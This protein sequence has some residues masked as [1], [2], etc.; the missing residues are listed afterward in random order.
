MEDIQS[1]NL[2]YHNPDSTWTAFDINNYQE[3]LSKVLVKGVF[4][5]KVP[6]DVINS[7][8]IYEHHVAHAW[9]SYPAMDDAVTKLVFTTEIAIKQ[10]CMQMGIDIR[11]FTPKGHKNINLSDL[12]D[13][14]TKVEPDK[15]LSGMLHQIRELRN[16]I[17]HPD[18]YSFGFG[19][20][21]LTKPIV[22]AINLLYLD[23]SVVKEQLEEQRRLQSEID[24]LSDGCF[25]ITDDKIYHLALRIKVLGSVKIKDDWYYSISAF[26]IDP[27]Y[28][29]HIP[30]GA[31]P[32]PIG[33]MA[34]NIKIENNEMNFWDLINDEQIK[35]HLSQKPEYISLKQDYLKTFEEHFA[36]DDFNK[37]RFEA[38]ESMENGKLKFDFLYQKL[39]LI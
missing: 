10:R 20:M 33:F 17:A 1:N 26:I 28:K 25:Y 11:K 24:N 23:N 15:D 34:R 5:K 38:L 6:V 16:S 29:I 35:I 7:Y 19:M 12:I 8:Q 31:C 36:N 9:Y 30:K 3:Y 4:H 27:K 22:A 18:N 2:P 14:L 13:E 37:H 21:N 32:P 39:H